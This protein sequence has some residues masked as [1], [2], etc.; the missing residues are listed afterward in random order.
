MGLEFLENPYEN[1]SDDDSDLVIETDEFPQHPAE[2]WDLP[3]NVSILFYPDMLY[4]INCKEPFRE[5]NS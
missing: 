4:H 5:N 2:E 1:K 3:Q